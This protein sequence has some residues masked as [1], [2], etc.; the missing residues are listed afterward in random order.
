MLNNETLIDYGSVDGLRVYGNPKTKR[1]EIHLEGDIFGDIYL[2]WK[3]RNS[4]SLK[5]IKEDL[6]CLVVEM[7]KK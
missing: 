3:Q 5:K 2:E 4:K 1:L 7:S 6:S